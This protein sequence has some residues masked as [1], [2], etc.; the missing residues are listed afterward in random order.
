MFES[1]CIRAHE[2]GINSH[3]IDIGKLGEALIF[4]QKVHVI[5]NKLIL[6]QLIESCGPELV[7]ELVENG[8]LN[9]TYLDNSLGIITQNTNTSNEIHEAIQ[10]SSP[11]TDLQNVTPEIFTKVLGKPGKARRLAGSFQKKINIFKH[12]GQFKE[13]FLKDVSQADYVKVCIKD[14]LNYYV[15]EFSLPDPIIFDLGF[16]GSVIRINSNINLQD[17]NEI[18]HKRI[19]SSHSSITN[20]Y[21]LSH[22]QDIGSDLFFS[23]NL[24]SELLV[25]PLHSKLIGNKIKKNL[26]VPLNDWSQIDSFQDFVLDDSKAISEAIN[27]GDKNFSDLLGVIHEANKFK[28]WLKDQDPNVEL[29]KSYFKEVTKNSWVDKLPG[30]STR[31]SL[32]TGAGLGLDALGAGGLGALTGI[33]LSALDTFYLDKIIKGWKPNQFIQELEDFIK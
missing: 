27:S 10:I 7:I 20:A 32:F 1:I 11:K 23:S 5:A 15:P 14:F 3:K 21:F 6:E 13:S 19:P 29:T 30:K 33:G 16:D 31:W 9:I 22:L 12:D 28:H 24:E 25:N 2:T 17:V 4:Y 26:D 18:Y 8:F